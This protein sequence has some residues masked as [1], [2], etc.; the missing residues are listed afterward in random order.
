MI[1]WLL[2]IF[3]SFIFGMIKSP[4]MLVILILMQTIMLS[5]MIFYT[6]MS[7]WM[8]YILILIFLGGM[9]VIF[10]YIASLSSNEKFNVSWNNYIYMIFFLMGTMIFMYCM[11]ENNLISQIFNFNKNLLFYQSDYVT[12]MYS[13]SM[14]LS[15]LFLALYL[16][17]TLFIIV[18]MSN[19]NKGPLRSK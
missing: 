17:I 13:F 16:M 12:N 19:M 10:I 9:L 14:M 3:M 4:L 15:T 5:L 8:S 7:F 1:M 11:N 6:H 18:K 2:I